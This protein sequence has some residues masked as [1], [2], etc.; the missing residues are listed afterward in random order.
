MH[1]IAVALAGVGAAELRLQPVRRAADGRGPRVV[2]R[3]RATCGELLAHPA[4]HGEHLHLAGEAHLLLTCEQRN[5][6]RLRQRKAIVS[7]AFHQRVAINQFDR[8]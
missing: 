8:G 6:L 5:T 3:R 2:A 1:H 4:P 7:D